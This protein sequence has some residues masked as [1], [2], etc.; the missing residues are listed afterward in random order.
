MSQL[1]PPEYRHI[2]ATPSSGGF[3]SIDILLLKVRKQNIACASSCSNVKNLSALDLCL[4]VKPKKK[5]NNAPVKKVMLW[6]VNS[7]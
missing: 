4:S 1:D 7:N 3:I 5:N 2:P 6:G